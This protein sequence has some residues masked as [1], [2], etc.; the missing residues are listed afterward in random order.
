[1]SRLGSNRFV[2]SFNSDGDLSLNQFK[3][4]RLFDSDTVGIPPTAGTYAIGIQENKPDS[5]TASEIRECLGGVTTAI[6]GE[7]ITAGADLV[8]NGTSNTQ[9]G[10]LYKAATMTSTD[11]IG[12]TLESGIVDQRVAILVNPRNNVL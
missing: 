12:K 1:M 10:A 3:A 2:E 7:T 9:T 8:A 11:I 5:I 6:L 4:V